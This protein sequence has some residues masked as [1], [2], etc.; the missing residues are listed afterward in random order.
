MIIT[1]SPGFA[2]RARAGADEEP[3]QEEVVG[4]VVVA[5]RQEEQQEEEVQLAAEK[6]CRA[7]TR[8]SA[9]FPCKKNTLCC[10]GTDVMLL[11][12]FPSKKPA[13]NGRF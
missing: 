12:I 1:L 2:R 4:R 11:K 10:P 7:Q 3:E 8:Q 9:F 13:K 5:L 6:R